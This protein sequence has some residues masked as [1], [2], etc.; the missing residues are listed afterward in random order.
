[1]EVCM[2]DTELSITTVSDIPIAT[3]YQSAPVDEQGLFEVNED[4]LEE[5]IEFLNLA[6]VHSVILY[7]FLSDN[8]LNERLNRGKYFGHRN[9]EGEL[10][11]IA[12]IGHSTIFDVRTDAALLAFAKEARRAT[13][14]INLIMSSGEQAE[15]FFNEYSNCLYAPR[16]RC[17]EHSFVT[18]YPFAVQASDRRPRLATADE[19]EPVARVQA[20]LALNESG[21]NPLA[22]DRDGFLSRV[23]RRIDQ[24][25]TYVVTENG[26]LIFKVDLMAATSE[27]AYL[28]GVYVAPEER[29][30][31][32]GSSCLSQVC[33]ELLSISSSVCLL[34]NREMEH[35]HKCFERA[36]MQRSDDLVTLFV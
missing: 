1:M 10:D 28:E 25:R 31:G 15:T 29:G 17:V 35:A 21:V 19:L 12:L 22:I 6:S 20:E 27:M 24:G 8:G 13:N 5:A 18:G 11:G 2:L 7:G 9:R 4:S 32:T 26:S 34:S 14:P 36:G 33:I 23:L 30:K 16:K 3:F